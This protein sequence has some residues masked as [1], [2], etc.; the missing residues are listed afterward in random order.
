MC[1]PSASPMPSP[2][3]QCRLSPPA[4]LTSARLTFRGSAG[5]PRPLQER[6]PP[7]PNLPQ[8]PPT[9][10]TPTSTSRPPK[11]TMNRSCPMSAPA[12]RRVSPATPARSRSPPPRPPTALLPMRSLRCRRRWKP[13][14]PRCCGPQTTSSNPRCPAAPTGRTPSTHRVAPARRSSLQ[15]LTARESPQLR[16]RLTTALLVSRCKWPRVPLRWLPGQPA[17]CPRIRGPQSQCLAS[18][19]PVQPESPRNC[20]PRAQHQPLHQLQIR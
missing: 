5:T 17:R 8:P 11:T 13:P 20:Q 1:W 6:S 12:P 18:L 2:C 15:T 19:K 3:Q 9:A 16:A 10:R 7:A 4:R 14:P